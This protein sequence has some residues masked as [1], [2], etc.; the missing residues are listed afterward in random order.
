[1][2]NRKFRRGQTVK[3]RGWADVADRYLG[4]KGVVST[5][6]GKLGGE[7]AY[8]LTIHDRVAPLVVTEDEITK[9]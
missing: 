7:F 5:L 3:V 8:G 4:R 9:A 6:E 2:A 1:M